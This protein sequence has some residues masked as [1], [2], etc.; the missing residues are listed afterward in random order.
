EPVLSQDRSCQAQGLGERQRR[1]PQS[2]VEV[3]DDPR[4]RRAEASDVLQDR[5]EVPD[6]VNE[7]GEDDE[8]EL[9]LEL[10]VVR[11]C[12]KEPKV[13]VQ[14]LSMGNCFFG[15]IHAHADTRSEARQKMPRPRAKLDDAA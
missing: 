8:I 1:L 3:E 12:P 7:I 10:E 4:S 13:R 9:L 6:V 11:V 15:E 14:P 5:L 2:T